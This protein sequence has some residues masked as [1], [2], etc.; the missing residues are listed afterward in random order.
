MLYNMFMEI[1]LII[2]IV[3][4]IT[5]LLFV[6]FILKKS[7]TAD[8]WKQDIHSKVAQLDQQSQASDIIHLKSCVIEAD[9]LLDHVFKQKYIQGETMG[10]RL[11]NAQRYFGRD[12]YNKVWQ[13]HKLRNRLAHEL[14][15]SPSGTDLKYEYQALRR[16]ILHMLS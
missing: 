5:S 10:D 1:I 16:A 11:K 12:Q 14:D 13:A 8:V 2:V 3:L 6:S 9:K 7:Q 15:Y 4:L